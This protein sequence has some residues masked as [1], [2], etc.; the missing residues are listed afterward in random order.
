MPIVYADRVKETTLTT[1]TGT[2]T[3]GGVVIGFQGFVAGIGFGNSTYYA[4]TKD[5][6]G[7]WEV[8]IGTVGAGT[9]SRD[10]VLASSNANALVN[11]AVGT[12]T[13]F[14]TTAA[15]FFA[16]GLDITSHAVV[17]HTGIPG[18]PPAESFTALVHSAVNHAGIPGVPPAESFTSPV[19]AVTNH[20]G[21]TGVGDLTT[22]AHGVLNHAGI[23][24]VGDLLTSVH[25]VLDHGGILGVV[26]LKQS[27]TVTNVTNVALTLYT[28]P[29]NTLTAD[30]DSLEMVFWLDGLGIA[31]DTA[32]IVLGGL[33]IVTL[34]S[35]STSDRQVY[36]LRVLR[37]GASAGSCTIH[38]TT[39]QAATGTVAHSGRFVALGFSWAASQAWTIATTVGNRHAVTYVSVNKQKAA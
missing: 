19:H 7:S 14:A 30:G 31:A 1:G 2:V 9:L 26:P 22:V 17:N 29:A 35:E 15:Q 8:G 32:T 25:A 27:S 36:T 33:T 38:R 16:N 23:P 18:V 10:T 24:G 12:K 34:E 20:A 37:T 13:V 4:I 5:S 28:I 3:L 11:F 6:D 21:I 39:L